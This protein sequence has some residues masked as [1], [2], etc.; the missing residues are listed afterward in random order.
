MYIGAREMAGRATLSKIFRGTL[1]RQAIA[2][3]PSKL[4]LQEA[5][6]SSIAF[7]RSFL[8]CDNLRQAL[9]TLEPSPM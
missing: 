8:E 9:T 1:D 6:D 4:A 7:N 2:G 3:R 5:R